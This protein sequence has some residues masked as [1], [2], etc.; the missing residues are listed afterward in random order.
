VGKVARNMEPN[1]VLAEFVRSLGWRGRLASLAALV[2]GITVCLALADSGGP[3]GVLPIEVLG[4]DGTTVNSTITLERQ[5]AD[6]VQSLWLRTNGLRYSSQGSLQVNDGAWIPLRNEN[7]AVDEPGKSYGGI[8]GGFVTLAMRIALPHGAAVAGMNTVRFRFNHTEGVSSGYRVLAWNFLT[9]EGAKIIPPE[10]FSK[11]NP[12]A[13]SAPLADKGAIEAGRELWQTAELVQ[14][15]EPNSPKIRAHCADCHTYDGRDLKYFNFSNHSIITRSRFHGLSALQGEQIASY[16]R[17]LPYPNPGRPWNPPYQP[18][19]GLDERPVTNWAAGAGIDWVLDQDVAALPQL[20]SQNSASQES[21]SAATAQALDAPQL[22]SQITPELFRPDGDLSA[23]QIPIALQLPDWNEWLPR[24]HPKDAWGAN[25]AQSEFGKLYADGSYPEGKR[26]G[27]KSTLRASLAASQSGDSNLHSVV[28]AFDRWSR[29]R[30][31]FLK[32]LVRSG[33]EWTPSLTDKVYSTELWQLVKTWEMTQEFGLEARGRDLYGPSADSRTWFNSVP[34]ETA[35]FSAQIPDGPAGVGGSALTN[36]YF[37]AAWYELQILLNSGNHQHH[38]RGPVDWVY[39]VGWFQGL[40]AQT[41]QPEPVRLLVAVIK[42]QQSTDPRLGPEDSHRGW[43]PDR[44][45][46]P[47]I[48][49]S[50]AW[51]P[52]FK[53]LPVEAR[54]ALTSAFLSAWMEKTLR[55]PISGYLPVGIRT[56][57]YSYQT[58]GEITGGEVWNAASQFRGA[59]V[60][61]DLLDRL[62][63]WGST[64]ADRAARIQYEGR[65]HSKM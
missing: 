53:P 36:A 46:D 27:G 21:L 8:G 48:M 30:R 32:N 24:I 6:T 1:G 34:S 56:E 2:A 23:R 4:E 50:P 51:A 28:N 43:Q 55:Y 65:P 9:A 15:S 49:V 63:E 39:M 62:L 40:Y 19:P 64:Y 58:Y 57:N 52:F 41:H 33:T 59:G 29:A 26:E 25:F 61:D 12:D 17:S 31:A 60:S 13:W 16:I 42:A 18:G 20:V 10:E 5:Q 11:D 45:L 14:N 3:R 44:N 7:V 35:P 22:L 47:R 37:N 38:D 54:R